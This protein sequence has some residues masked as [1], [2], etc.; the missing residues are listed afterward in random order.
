[1]VN[2]PGEQESSARVAARPLAR[3]SARRAAFRRKAAAVAE[4]RQ[5]RRPELSD[6]A[7]RRVQNSAGERVSVFANKFDTIFRPSEN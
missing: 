6:P 7:R 4:N 3:R 2:G 1:M 5:P